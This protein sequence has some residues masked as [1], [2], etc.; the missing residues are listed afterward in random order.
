VEADALDTIAL[1]FQFDQHRIVRN[2]DSK[3]KEINNNNN[4]RE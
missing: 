3:S 4:N 2:E 1:S